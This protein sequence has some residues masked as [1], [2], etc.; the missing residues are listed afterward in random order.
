MIN[1]ERYIVQVINLWGTMS[2]QPEFEPVHM[3]ELRIVS[4]EDVHN[5]ELQ[6]RAYAL[7]KPEHVYGIAAQQPEITMKAAQLALSYTIDWQERVGWINVMYKA[8]CPRND[9]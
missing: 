5:I 8:T 2:V 7:M 3:P 9:N 4:A 6:I 1:K